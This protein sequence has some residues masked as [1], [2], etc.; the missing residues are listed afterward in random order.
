MDQLLQVSHSVRHYADYLKEKYKGNPVAINHSFPTPSK[1][2]IDLALITHDSCDVNKLTPVGKVDEILAG[3]EVIS[4]ENILSEENKTLVVIQGAAGIGKSTLAWEMCRRWEDIAAM[5]QFTLVEF[6]PLGERR[7]SKLEDLFSHADTKLKQSVADETLHGEGKGVLL[8]L[9]GF[10][11]LPI[12]D[13]RHQEIISQVIKREIFPKCS[14]L[15]T[16]RPSGTR[17]L[18][19]LCRPRINTHIEILGFTQT[20]IETYAASILKPEVCKEFLQYISSASNPGLN[21]LMYVPLNAA[22][23]ADIYRQN[24]PKITR[25][26]NTLTQ[27]YT[28]LCLTILQCHYDNKHKIDSFDDLPNS[29]KEHFEKLSRLAFEGFRANETVYTTQQIPV[30]FGFLNSTY[31]TYSGGETSYSFLHLS[32]QEFLAAYHISHLIPEA[33]GAEILELYH[34]DEQWS[35]VWK[36][37]AGL[38]D[39]KYFENS[40][41]HFVTVFPETIQMTPLLVHCLFEAQIELDYWKIFQRKVVNVCSKNPLDRYALGYCIAN[42]A[43]SVWWEVKLS[44]GSI[45]NFVWGLKSTR[46]CAGLISTLTLSGCSQNLSILQQ[47]PPNILQNI[48]HFQL[49]GCQYDMFESNVALLPGLLAQMTNM[50][51]LELHHNE[52]EGELANILEQLSESK[53]TSLILN[54]CTT[55]LSTA[56]TFTA[57]VRLTD[58][59]FGTLHSLTIVQHQ[60]TEM[61]NPKQL[62]NFIFGPTSLRRL[63]LF[64]REYE[65]SS[66]D[67]LKYNTHFTSLAISW[68]HKPNITTL[69]ETLQHNSTIQRLSLGPFKSLEEDKAILTEITDALAENATL[70]G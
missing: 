44:K 25:S 42:S 34:R 7:V 18:L 38:S 10:D 70:S 23:I 17:N 59:S 41:Q 20:S 52:L 19:K 43:P 21:E 60:L 45:D 26:L 48:K 16:T 53:V 32:V 67:L 9:D 27:L 68:S 58:P 69:V 46:N 51:K 15:V 22:I 4:I 63:K 33:D 65:S 54:N 47:C 55:T 66:L 30:H 61:F 12:T 2:Y 57:L 29:D 64:L 8:I 14:V 49:S 62:C 5:R 31:T 35:L 11:D 50:R 28:G 40:P 6:I 13:S 36:F 39:F 56:N 1:K 3:R 24:R 37:T